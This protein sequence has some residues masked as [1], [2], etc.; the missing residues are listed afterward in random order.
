MSKLLYGN[1]PELE[2]RLLDWAAQR[3]G[4]GI[5]AELLKPAYA[6]GCVVD[7]T[8][9]AV[10][11]FNQLRNGSAEIGIVS[12]SP[13]WLS[14][15]ICTHIAAFAFDILKLRRVTGITPRKN[16]KARAL[17]KRLGFIEEATLK[18]GYAPGLDAVVYRM[19]REE[20]RWLKSSPRSTS[21]LEH[22]QVAGHA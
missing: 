5:T 1:N 21:Y 8:L 12:D 10:V 16:K 7:D 15:Q 4:F 14:R 6:I 17:A 18:E 22:A 3:L 11:F 19:L 9:V 20:C 13:A 2:H